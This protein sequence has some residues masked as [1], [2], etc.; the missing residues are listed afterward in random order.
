V[1]KVFKVMQVLLADVVNLVYLVL[2]VQLEL[3]V[4]RDLL[5]NEAKRVQQVC[6]FVV[7]QV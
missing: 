4:Q 7:N 3:L 1:L 2:L 6:L 5:V